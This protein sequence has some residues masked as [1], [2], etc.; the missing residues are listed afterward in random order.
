MRRSTAHEVDHDTPEGP[1]PV[2]YVI[3]GAGAG[4]AF[5]IAAALLGLWVA[6]A[7]VLA[8]AGGGWIGLIFYRMRAGRY[9]AK[10]AW[11]V[12]LRRGG[13]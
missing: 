13:G 2:P 4:V 3:A 12:L 10:G 1:G 7:T 9:D 8:G 6:I 11:N 5:A